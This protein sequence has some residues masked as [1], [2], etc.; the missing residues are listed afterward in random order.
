MTPRTSISSPVRAADGDASGSAGTVSS[1]GTVIPIRPAQPGIIRLSLLRASLELKTFFRQRDSAI[2]T[3]ALPIVLLVIFGQ[4]FH[5]QIG[6]TGVSIRQYF[7]AG[8]VA[9]GL[10]STTFVSLG[11]GIAAD[12]DDGTLK[13]LA[14][15]PL[16]PAAYFAGKAIAALVACTME[17]AVMLAFSVVLL[18]LRLPDTA[19]RWLTFGWVF[20]LSA[21]TC[22]MLGAAI[23]LTVRSSRTA[24]SVL[25][26]P[27]LALTAISGVYFVFNSLPRDIQQ[28]AAVFPLKWICQGLQ[29]AF[30]PDRILAIEPTHSW[31]LGR[32]ALVLMA[33]LVASLVLCVRMYRW[34]RLDER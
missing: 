12:R 6:H 26:L 20:A 22:A 13:R 21:V 34:Q 25:N 9:S 30:L 16:P 24:S 32:V 8:I 19:S 3:F 27:Y 28:I 17:V 14:G 18:G 15:T 11:G 4:I 1:A 10:M 5:G 31:E 2:F 33:W 23:G 7:V 29:S